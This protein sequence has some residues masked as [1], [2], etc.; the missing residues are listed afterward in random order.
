MYLQ[1]GAGILKN[2]LSIQDPELL[3]Q[4]VDRYVET[5]AR[6][7]RRRPLPRP[8]GFDYGYFK[9]IHHHFFQDV[10]SWAGK[11]RKIDVLKPEELFNGDSVG[12]AGYRSIRRLAKRAIRN[13][14]EIRWMD[15]CLDDQAAAFAAC[16][17]ELWRVHTFRD[18]NTRVVTEFCL[19]YAESLGLKLDRTYF[20]KANS[21]RLR[22]AL[23]SANGPQRTI[24][25]PTAD[26]KADPNPLIALVKASMLSARTPAPL[27]PD[28][29]AVPAAM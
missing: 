26:I 1:Y 22:D 19:Q 29:D 16:M 13:M 11:P 20:G 4:T 21:R 2:K 25:S 9:S 15:L 23:V 24:N 12:Y 7:L 6:Q 3:S 5:R 18:G 28:I 17:A 8:E 10:Y 27:R 14:K